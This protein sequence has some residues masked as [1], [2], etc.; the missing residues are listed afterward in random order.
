VRTA[1]AIQAATLRGGCAV[2]AFRVIAEDFLCVCKKLLTEWTIEAFFARSLSNTASVLVLVRAIHIEA[3]RKIRSL[4]VHM[5]FRTDHEVACSQ[6]FTTLVSVSISTLKSFTM[7]G[8][9]ALDPRVS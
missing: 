9:M 6:F 1:T 3:E 4:S 8:G 5:M 2:R 7:R